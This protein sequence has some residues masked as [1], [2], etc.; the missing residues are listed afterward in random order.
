MYHT[1]VRASTY[2]FGGHKKI[3]SRNSLVVQ[4]LGLG[5]FTAMA[6]VWSLV[7]EL[8]SCKLRGTA[9]QKFSL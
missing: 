6:Q 5:A 4:Y 3:Q 2:G 7:W 1:E 9:K 8:R